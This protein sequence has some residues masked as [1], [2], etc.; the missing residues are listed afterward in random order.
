[1]G[2][3]GLGIFWLVILWAIRMDFQESV[4][5]LLGIILIDFALITFQFAYARDPT[6]FIS[7]VSGFGMCLSP[8]TKISY[9]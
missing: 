9:L 5:E 7:M 1:M 6:P 4:F 3:N 2:K 8:K